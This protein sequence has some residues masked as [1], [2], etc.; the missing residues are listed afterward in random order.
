MS[1]LSCVHTKDQGYDLL[2]LWG[3]IHIVST[4]HTEHNVQ[5][6]TNLYRKPYIRENELI[7]AISIK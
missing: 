4:F 3:T 5:G 6:S 7:T 2:Q 1:R